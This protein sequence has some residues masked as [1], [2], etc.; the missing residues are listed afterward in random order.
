MET[1]TYKTGPNACV[2]GIYYNGGRLAGIRVFYPLLYGGTVR[3]FKF[4][5]GKFLSNVRLGL[6]ESKLLSQITAGTEIDLYNTALE[7]EVVLPL[8][9][10]VLSQI[11]T[12]MGGTLACASW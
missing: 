5:E 3:V 8:E 6:S 7:G 9:R 10:E 4:Q 12:G 2:S 1:V 11:R